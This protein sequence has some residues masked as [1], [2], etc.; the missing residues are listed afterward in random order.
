MIRHTFCNKKIQNG[1]IIARRPQYQNTFT[2]D[3]SRTNYPNFFKLCV[4]NKVSVRIVLSRGYWKSKCVS[5]DLSKRPV[6][7]VTGPKNAD[8]KIL[9]LKHSYSSMLHSHKISKENHT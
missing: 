3:I 4:Q 2:K 8:F 5:E 7:I 6:A 1:G 9:Y